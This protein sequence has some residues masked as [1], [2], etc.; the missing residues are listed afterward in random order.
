MH[1]PDYELSETEK[2]DF[3]VLC[4]ESFL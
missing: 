2:D 4:Y 3:A 1:Y